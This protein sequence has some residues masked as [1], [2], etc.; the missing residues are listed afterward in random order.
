MNNI[1]KIMLA[2]ALAA[3]LAGCETPKRAIAPPA[4]ATTVLTVGQPQIV[5]APG[6]YLLVDQQPLVLVG[7]TSV[8]W[9]LPPDGTYSEFVV[10]IGQDRKRVK[11][12][13]KTVTYSVI[14]KPTVLNR[15]LDCGR[16]EAGRVTCQLPLAVLEKNTVYS[17]TLGFIRDGIKYELDPD[18]ML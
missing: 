13:G 12:D 6:G 17:Y 10:T 15:K 18:M 9:Q 3:A 5:I 11:T 14:E 16:V 2:A 7:Q 8:T 4:D 1:Y